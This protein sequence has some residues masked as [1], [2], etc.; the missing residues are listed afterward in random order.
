VAPEVL[1]P[2]NVRFA[3]DFDVYI[4][5]K[6]FTN[7]FINIFF[8]AIIIKVINNYI[9]PFFLLILLVKKKE[10]IKRKRRLK[11]RSVGGFKYLKK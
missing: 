11:V 6:V 10:F 5:A 7:K 1:N 2:E 8:R 4:K 3:Y 9:K